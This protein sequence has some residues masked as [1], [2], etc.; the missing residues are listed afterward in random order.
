MRENKPKTSKFPLA[1]NT[2]ISQSF[3]HPISIKPR[4]KSIAENRPPL[5][6]SNSFASFKSKTLT[7]PEEEAS[8]I[9][10]EKYM[11]SASIFPEKATMT[12]ILRRVE[13]VMFCHSKSALS[14]VRTSPQKCAIK[15]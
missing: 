8:I 12:A 2:E 11:A 7:I 9:D 3:E 15:T 5:A 10:V 14:T 1:E 4:P 13:K 6:R